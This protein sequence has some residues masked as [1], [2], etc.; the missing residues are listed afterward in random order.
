MV[1]ITV[2]VPIYGVERYIERS[3]HSLFSQTKREGVEYILVNDVTPDKS[4]NIAKRV[5]SN[6]P[7]INAQIIDMPQ[8]GGVAAARKAA[9]ERATGEYVIHFDPDDWC[10]PNM[11][12]DMLFHA[13]NTE[14]DIVI[15][16]FVVE[17][18]GDETYVK[19]SVPSTPSGCVESLLRGEL[20]GALWNKLVKKSLY[21]E[22]NITFVEG[23]NF[24]ED[25]LICT[26]LFSIASSVAYLPNAYLHYIHN[27][28]SIVANFSQ[29][30]LQ[31]AIE[32]VE[33]IERF[34]EEH[35][36]LERFGSALS[37]RKGILKIFLLR[38]CTVDMRREYSKLFGR[39]SD[40]VSLSGVNG[41]ALK[42][43]DRGWFTFFD[44]M[45]SCGELLKRIK[46]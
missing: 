32:V 15:C 19:Q 29:S 2:I 40:S 14:S 21:T 37:Y 22:N 4:I 11:L 35:A 18:L 16:D 6:Y 44:I 3:L 8:N 27:T 23:V 26:K 28:G 31:N 41:I 46:K 33:R 34:F 24:M 39:V 9:L 5:I 42:A 12:E 1:D 7:H 10:D 17:R 43:V 25:L 13:K 30:K 36:L 45:I 20:H 38:Y